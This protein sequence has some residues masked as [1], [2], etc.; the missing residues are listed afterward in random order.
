MI[1]VVNKTRLAVPRLPLE[2]IFKEVF[3]KR[4]IDVSVAFV[5]DAA[6]R[7]YNRTYRKKDT[8]T[9]VLAFLL[10]EHMGELIISPRRAMEEA[11]EE[12]VSLENRL[13]RLLI[14]GLMHLSGY[15][16]EQDKD[17]RVMERKEEAIF[18]KITL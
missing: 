12:G 14:H 3:N 11:K 10:D 16:H 9:N 5:G 13:V 6:M 1:Q 17:A 8:I 7:T 18:K 4:S 2:K 15:D